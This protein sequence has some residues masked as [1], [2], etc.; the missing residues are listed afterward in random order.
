VCVMGTGASQERWTGLA[1]RPGE[2][3]GTRPGH[4]R[5]KGGAG[6]GSARQYATSDGRGWVTTCRYGIPPAPRGRAAAR[7][8]ALLCPNPRPLPPAV[9]HESVAPRW[10]GPAQISSPG[11]RLTSRHTVAPN[12]CVYVR[13]RQRPRAAARSPMSEPRTS[14]AVSGV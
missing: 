3:R 5:S 13:R 11:S 8:A 9:A 12:R 6:R 2:R 7:S 14:H 4:G 1:A 10:A